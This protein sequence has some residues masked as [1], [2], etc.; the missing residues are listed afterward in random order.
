[1]STFLIKSATSQSSSHR[2]VLTRLGGPRSRPNSHL[3]FVEVAGYRTR[4]PMLSSHTLIL[5]IIIH[6]EYFITVINLKIY[7]RVFELKHIHLVRLHGCK[8]RSKLVF[9]IFS[10]E[11]IQILDLKLHFI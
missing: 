11:A 6:Q 5:G 3:K 7:I 10:E 8:C 4:D 2:I 9:V 1:M